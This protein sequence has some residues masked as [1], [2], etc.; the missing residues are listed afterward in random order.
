MQTAIEKLMDRLSKLEGGAQAEAALITSDRNRFYFTGFPSSAGALLILRDAAYFMT[1]FRYGEA[2]AKSI[3]GCEVVCYSSMRE[4]LQQLLKKHG[5]K[6]VLLENEKMYLQESRV[7]TDILASA[8]AEAVLDDTL[9][10]MIIALRTIKTPEEIQKIRDSQKITDD[11]FSY[12][13][14]RIAPGR[15]EREIALE[16]EFFMRKQG[17]EGVAFE[18][19]VVSGANGSMCHGV[20]SEKVIE[21]G[22]FITMDTGALLNGY[23]SDMTRTVA[24]GQVSEEQRHVYE[25]VL[26]AQKAAI[27]A[28]GPGVPCGDVDKAARDLIE[29]EYPYAFGHSTGHGVGV[30]IHEWP[31]FQKGNTQKA[32]PG[33]VVTVEPGIY[34]EGKFGVRIEDMIAITEDGIENLTHSPKELLIL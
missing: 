19:I 13:L 1:D 8:G 18:L 2:A 32:E 14:G 10:K 31:R 24:V 21:K 20:P 33:M 16:I 27:A 26:K 29:A 34:L 17:A 22:D 4:T 30:E 7:L 6:K 28:A 15:T 23:H 5:V 11:A 25:L 12:I 9:D 3:H